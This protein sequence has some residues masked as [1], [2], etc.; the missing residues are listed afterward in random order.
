MTRIF[1]L[2]HGSPDPRSG[3]AIRNFAAR[4][5][6]R[7]GLS[8][9]AAF[10]DHDH[11][12]LAAAANVDGDVDVYHDAVVLPMLLST[13]FHA[14]FDV[15]KAVSEAGL[16]RVLPPIGHPVELL[17]SLIQRAG[18]NVIVVAAGTTDQS[19]R[20]L[21][22][23]TVE[24]AAM[25]SGNQATPAF[26]TGPESRLPDKLRE[27]Q[28]S[29]SREVIVIPWLVAEGRLLDTI[30][31]EAART[32]AMVQGGGLVNETAFIEY[33]TLTIMSAVEMIATVA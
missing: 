7:I 6:T 17:T 8:T 22:K 19:A 5:Q 23:R 33:I 20:Q 30:H 2:A 10:L 11:P 13:A 12:N 31:T 3:N 32:G 16:T 24:I 4:I 15:P 29:N 25:R 1:L 27:V 26:I 14:R 28:D 9:T 21:F 18:A